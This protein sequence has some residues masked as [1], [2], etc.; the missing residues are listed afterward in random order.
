MTTIEWFDSVLPGTERFE[1]FRER[2]INIDELEAEGKIVAEGQL[3]QHAAV[4]ETIIFLGQ[5][6]I[7]RT[8]QPYPKNYKKIC[9]LN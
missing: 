6:L 4:G 1:R 7:H 2:S 5:H 3:V 9:L 8:Q